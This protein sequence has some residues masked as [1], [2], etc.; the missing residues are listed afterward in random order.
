M[1]NLLHA[2]NR[3]SVCGRDY[4]ARGLSVVEAVYL[5]IFGANTLDRTNKVPPQEFFS[6][7]RPYPHSKS[8][9]NECYN[10]YVFHGLILAK[11]A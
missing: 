5:H 9:N 3:R 4:I 2:T 6:G 1:T 11:M 7:L 8:D 10:R